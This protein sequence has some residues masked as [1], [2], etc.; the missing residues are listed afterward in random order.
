[1]IRSALWGLFIKIFA[2]KGG[3]IMMA[4][5]FAQRVVLGKASFEAVYGDPKFIPDVLKQAVADELKSSGLE[6]LVP[7]EYGGTKE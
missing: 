6:F 1:M 7:K 3:E 2:R 5:F 4:I